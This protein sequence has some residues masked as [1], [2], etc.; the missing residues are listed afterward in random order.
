[1]GEIERK[2]ER[3]RENEE[4]KKEETE[5]RHAMSLQIKQRTFVRS[6]RS[7]EWTL[8]LT[9]LAFTTCT[10]VDHFYLLSVCLSEQSLSTVPPKQQQKQWEKW[11]L[12]TWSL[13]W[14]AGTTTTTITTITRRPNHS[15]RFALVL[16]VL[17]PLGLSSGRFFAWAHS[18]CYSFARSLLNGLQTA[19]KNEC[20]QLA[21]VC[22][23]GPGRKMVVVMV[24][25]RVPRA[26]TEGEKKWGAVAQFS[27]LALFSVSR[28]VCVCVMATGAAVTMRRFDWG[29]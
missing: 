29:F 17:Q 25:A 13:A 19:P 26:K 22:P 27:A 28:C 1:M 18:L 10:A 20:C 16:A 8:R 3:E 23:L 7:A 9:A 11:S 4:G 24:V 6:H 21:R 14:F 2:R 12:S 15:L 5:G